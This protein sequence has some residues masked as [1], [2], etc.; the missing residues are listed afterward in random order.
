M[1]Q[2]RLVMAMV[3]ALVLL[4]GCATMGDNN[5]ERA[6]QVG[7]QMT[8]YYQFVYDQATDAYVRGDENM[9]EYMRQEVNPELNR[10]KRLLIA[11]LEAVAL[12]QSTG[13]E[14]PE[15]INTEK[16]VRDI[17]TAVVGAL[18]RDDNG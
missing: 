3:M 14:P 1:T 8:N 7:V 6:A 5:Q 2:V 11:Y 9:R 10:A 15:M 12:W 16:T 13:E 17:L 4:I 18:R